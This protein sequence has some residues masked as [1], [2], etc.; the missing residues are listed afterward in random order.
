[1]KNHTLYK[2][3]LYDFV[4]GKLSKNEHEEINAHLNKCAECTE[5][6]VSLNE[7]LKIFSLPNFDM[8]QKS[9]FSTLA[10]RVRERAERK[11]KNA[12]L[13]FLFENRW[14]A[15]LASLLMIVSSALLLYNLNSEE[16]A[17]IVQDESE[18]Y[19]SS[20]QSEIYTVTGLSATLSSDEWELLSAVIDDEIGDIVDIFQYDSNKDMQIDRLSE[21]EWQ[22]FYKN[23]SKQN[24][25]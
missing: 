5:N 13:L 25:L 8:P 12:L 7:T 15:A 24:I 17:I 10:P 20:F 14:I 4:M 2:S 16:S 23:F 1:M 3:K 18:Y 21:N 22:E 6:I 9:Y 19:Y 11:E